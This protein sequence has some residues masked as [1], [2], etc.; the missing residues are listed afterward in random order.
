[1]SRSV[2]VLAL[3]TV[4]VVASLFVMVST[5]STAADG[6]GKLMLVMDSSGSMK[7]AAEGGTTKIAAAKASLTSV[8]DALPA[9]QPVGLRVYGAK[10]FSRSD[11]GACEDTQRVVD[12]GTDNRAALRAAV[13]KYQPYGETP[14]GNALKAAAKDLGNSGHRSI[15]LVSDGEPTCSPDPCTVAAE[16]TKQGINLSIDVIGLDVDSAARDKL[17]CIAKAGQGSYYD[18]KDTKQLTTALTTVAQRAAK[19]YQVSGTPITGGPDQAHATAIR[20][21]LWRTTLPSP[22][23]T[24]PDRW[25]RFTRTIKN[26]RVYLTASVVNG[27][28]QSER[29]HSEVYAAV[30]DRCDYE[31]QTAYNSWS[32]VVSAAASTG[33][34]R[35]DNACSTATSVDFR[36]LRENLTDADQPKADREVTIKVVEEPPVDPDASLPA[37]QTVGTAYVPE[38]GTAKNVA[39]GQSITTATDLTSGTYAGTILPGEA[40]LF[41]VHVDWGQSLASVVKVSQLP[42]N[43]EGYYRVYVNLLSPVLGDANARETAGWSSTSSSTSASAQSTPIEY[44]NR[45]ASGPQGAASIAGDY[46]IAVTVRKYIASQTT[47]VEVPFLMA[48]DVTGTAQDAPAYVGG[49]SASGTTGSNDADGAGQD[50]A[51]QDSAAKKSA[52]KKGAGSAHGGSDDHSIPWLPLGLGAGGAV[53]VG[54]AGIAVA[55]AVSR[56]KRTAK[57]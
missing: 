22:T 54:G 27:Q 30:D 28:D 56:R 17:T 7:E 55:Y 34:Y 29:I 21:G 52:T 9:D 26:S 4:V 8:I 37:A 38:L 39:G 15:V 20:T 11:K 32:P 6:V 51:S 36:V 48:V 46:L 14:I 2:Q 23:A 40:Q 24:T 3:A 10:V 19:P 13:A 16:L 35:A 33:P 49:S 50:S 43:A 25:F 12:L 53:L 41:K 44:A 18:A 47:D 45:D 57:Q 31:T 42:S 1:M 5:P